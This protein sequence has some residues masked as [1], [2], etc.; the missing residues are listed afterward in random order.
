MEPVFN[1]AGIESMERKNLGTRHAIFLLL[2]KPSDNNST[3]IINQFNYY[4][5][6]SRR[7]CS[8][9]A[10]GYSLVHFP[11]GYDNQSAAFVEGREWFYSD[12]CFV[13]FQVELEKRLKW[14]YCGEPEI[15]ILQSAR[16][17]HSA[18][19]FTNYVSLDVMRGLR[20]GYIDSFSRLMQELINASKSEV[21]AKAVLNK[22]KK[23][24][25]HEIFSTAIKLASPIPDELQKLMQDR[26]FYRTALKRP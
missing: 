8:I 5:F 4:H 13:E 12:R 24:S 20:E 16:G 25:A 11:N 1:F 17:K 9:Y 3:D 23:L 14:R 19:D 21:E 10:P 26:L 18:L 7:Y 6:A 15:I 22:A 2:V